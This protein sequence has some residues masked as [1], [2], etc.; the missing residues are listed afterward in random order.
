MDQQFIQWIVGQSGVA[1]VATLALWMLRQAYQDRDRS[2]REMIEREKQVSDTMIQALQ[3]HTEA[4]AKNTAALEEL[5]RVVAA[6]RQA[7]DLQV[8]V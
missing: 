8:R 3:E 2:H 4:V 1:G 7:A 5:Q 6:T